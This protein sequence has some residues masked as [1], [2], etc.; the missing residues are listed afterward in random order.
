MS[1][2]IIICCEESQAVCKEFRALGY[3]AYSNDLKPCTGGHPEWHLQGDAFTFLDSDWDLMIAHPPCTHLASS[4]R[5]WFKQKRKDGRMQSGIDL[6]LRFTEVKVPRWCIENPIGVMSTVYR[7]P[8]QIIQPWHFGDEAQ[9]STCLW[10]KKL[11]PLFHAKEVDLFNQDIT[12]VGKGEFIDLGNGT[13]MPKWFALP[14]SE[15]RG[16]IRSKTFPGIAKAMAK[17]WSEVL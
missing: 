11:P 7:K 15:E 5:A 3:E 8:D 4:G 16:T 2:K 17:Q 6:F 12:H 1:K 14:Q 10:L 9:K 13:R